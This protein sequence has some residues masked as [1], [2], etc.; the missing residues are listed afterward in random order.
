MNDLINYYELLGIKNDAT[1]DEIKKAYRTIAKKWHP[2]INKEQNASTMIVVLNEAKEILL[3]DIKRREYDD[4][5][6]NKTNPVYDDIK[7]K[8]ESDSSSYQ[9]RESGQTFAEDKMYTKWQYFIEYIKY[10]NTSVWIKILVTIGVLFETIICG[11]LQII[12]ILV[13]YLFCIIFDLLN[14]VLNIIIGLFTMLVILGIF[15]IQ[16]GETVPFTPMNWIF[17]FISLI[18]C[19]LFVLLPQ[20]TIRFLRNSMPYYLSKLNIYLF[21]KCV[22]YKD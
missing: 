16:I 9:T 3:D 15:M 8:S 5:L 1:K 10:Y 19:I 20:Y 13:A 14:S 6:K 4:Y 17:L 22:G 2:D 21:K 11:T 12:N 7:R 18:L